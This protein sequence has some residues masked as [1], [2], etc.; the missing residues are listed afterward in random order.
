MQKTQSNIVGYQYMKRKGSFK[1]SSIAASSMMAGKE[2]DRAS[3]IAADE[4]EGKDQSKN[5]ERLRQRP[6]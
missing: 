4:L 6:A 2:P 1:G 3:Q 5:P